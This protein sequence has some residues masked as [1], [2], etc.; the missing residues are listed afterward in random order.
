MR[1]GR[2]T[3]RRQ[4]SDRPATCENFAPDM[5]YRPFQT[6]VV[7]SCFRIFYVLDFD[8]AF[9]NCPDRAVLFC[10]VTVGLKIGIGSTPMRVIARWLLVRIP[11]LMFLATIVRPHGREW[12]QE[13][14]QRAYNRRAWRHVLKEYRDQLSR[15]NGHD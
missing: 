5:R 8:V 7:C 2:G 14:L 4:S 9:G 15:Y 3:S 1:F 6:A 13:L 11:G 10:C 12:R